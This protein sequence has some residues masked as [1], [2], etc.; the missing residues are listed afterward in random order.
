MSNAFSQY[1][2]V[3]PSLRA[4][5]SLSE[6]VSPNENTAITKIGISM[7]AT[8]RQAKMISQLRRSQAHL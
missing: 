3:K 1:S 8:A 6:E 2:S 7:Y 5:V 4:K